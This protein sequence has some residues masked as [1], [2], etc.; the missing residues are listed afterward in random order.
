LGKGNEFSFT[1]VCLPR[2]ELGANIKDSMKKCSQLK[3]QPK[4]SHVRRLLDDENPIVRKG[5]TEELIR[6]PKEGL[7][8]LEQVIREP[9]HLLAKHAHNL[10]SELGWVD[11]VEGFLQ[12][13]N[14]QRYELES[15]W[16]LLDRTVSPTFD[17]S[18]STLFL[19][20][21]ADRVR[22]LLLPPHTP[23]EMCS[24]LNRVLFHEFGFRGARKDFNDPQ[25][26]F[27]HRVLERKRGLPITLSVVY[28]LVARRI[29]FELDPIGLPGRFMVGCF[30]ETKPFYIDVWS[31]G[32]FLE[33]EQMAD[34]LDDSSIEDSGSLL[35]PVTVAE[36]LTRGCRNLVQQYGKLGDGDN[37]RLFTKFVIEFE[38][39]QQ[40][41]ANA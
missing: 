22:E 35:L 5:L 9:D 19:D 33:I 37:A 10:L 6:F 41:E 8:F 32:K 2:V 39:I 4:W 25:N 3:Q 14:S 16:F 40:R 28:I 31:G 12:F 20:S 18:S 38:N 34:F 24:V 11:G 23:K 36:T 30:S 17:V 7:A 21:L 13:I 26:S 1:E 15:G 29:G 27:L